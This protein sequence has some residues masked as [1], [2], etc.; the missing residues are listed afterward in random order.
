MLRFSH[1][2]FLYGLFLIPLLTALFWL[3]MARKKRVL[4][5]FGNMSLIQRLM[6]DVSNARQWFRFTL[7][8]LGFSSL[9]LALAN[10]QTGSKLEKA[11][12]KGVDLVVALDVS[13]S[14]LAEDIQPNRL[15]RAKQAISRLIDRLE[16][17]RLGLVVFAG[18]AYTQLP[19]TNDFGAARLFLSTVSPDLIPVQE[20][21][22]ADA[23]EKS[24]MAFND[25][26]RSR[27]IIIISDGEDHEGNTLERAQQEAEKGIKIFTIGMGTYEGSVIPVY[28]EG[29]L[30]GYKKDKNNS[31]VISRLN[32]TMLQQIASAGN[33]FF[34]RASNTEVGLNKIFDEINKMEKKEVETALFTDYEDQFQ[35]FVFLALL[36]FVIEFLLFERKSRWFGKLKLFEPES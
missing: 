33:G 31:T 16:D 10:P 3:M 29:K 22:I 27:V 7:V 23:I 4:E 18:R 2:Y 24:A 6:P 13:N 32:E 20:T 14:M 26:A 9:I 11:K 30:A 17:D 21:A 25:P 15:E 5:H 12:R 34:I 36:F 8:M 1:H 19:I 35:Y 28:R